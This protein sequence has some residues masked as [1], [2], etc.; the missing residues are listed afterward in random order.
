MYNLMKDYLIVQRLSRI[1][2]R[3]LQPGWWALLIYMAFIA[4]CMTLQP[5]TSLHPPSNRGR[6]LEMNAWLKTV[7][8]TD[9][10]ITD[11][12]QK[13]QISITLTNNL[14]R[15]LREGKYL[16]KVELLPGNPQPEDVVLL[17]QFDRYRQR[18]S[19][20]VFQSSDS[21][22]VSGMLILTRADGHFIKEVRASLKEEHPVDIFSTE[23]ALPSGMAARTYVIEE[24]LWKALS[25]LQPN[26]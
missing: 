18:R 21:S 26:S 23:A 4:G 10:E 20:Q 17:F 22:D 16:R 3:G 7:E 6:H 5:S 19:A 8:I 15:F 13:E 2:D 24:L 11:T 12:K 1:E 14:L 25:A 9:P